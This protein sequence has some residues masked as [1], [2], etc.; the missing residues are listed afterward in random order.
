MKKSD[1]ERLKNECVLS[2]KNLK[3]RAQRL[4]RVL[5]LGQLGEHQTQCPSRG[6]NTRHRPQHPASPAVKAAHGARNNSPGKDWTWGHAG[7]ASLTGPAG[8]RRTRQPR[9]GSSLQHSRKQTGVSPLLRKRAGRISQA[10]TSVTGEETSD[11]DGNL[12][13]TTETKH[14][15]AST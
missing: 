12:Q 2:L 15:L 11:R 3:E 13:M 7:K 14:K 1:G 5:G 10:L 9:S 8:D 4:P 6:I